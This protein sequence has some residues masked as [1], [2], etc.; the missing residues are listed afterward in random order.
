MNLYKSPYEAYPFL[1]DDIDDL[2]CDFEI[3]TDEISSQTGLLHAKVTEPFIQDELLWI[4]EI[5]YHMNP[6]LRT[7]LTVT[8]AEKEKLLSIVNRLKDEVGSRCKEFVLTQGCETACLSH[9][10]RVQCK[11]LVRLLYRYNHLGNKV[12]P[13]LFDLANLLSGYFFYLALKLNEIAE[14][15]EIAYK[16]RNYN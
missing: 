14:E 8:D 12:P 13:S 16:S 1:S 15:D 6:T 7:R 10:L 11:K 2:R 9:V 4:C 5:V 3:L